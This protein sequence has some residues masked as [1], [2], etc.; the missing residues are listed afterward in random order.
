MSFYDPNQETVVA[1]DSSSYGLGGVLMQKFNGVLKPICYAS[2][3]LTATEQRYA[4]IEKEAL[5]LTWACEKFRTYLIGLSFHLQTDHKPL[6]ALF[7][8][9]NLD[10]LPPRIQRFRMRMMWFDYKVVY[11][12]GKLLSIADALS[13]SPICFVATAEDDLISEVEDHVNNVVTNFPAS[14]KMLQTI[15]DELLADPICSTVIKYCEGGWPSSRSVCH[16][17]QTFYQVRDD[18]AHQKGLLL[19]GDRIVIPLALQKEILNKLHQSH[20]GITKSRARARTVWWPGLSGDIKSFV[21]N[22][23]VCAQLRTNPTEPLI[24][25]ELPECSWQK[26]ACDL[27]N[28]NNAVYLL[29][30][31]YFSRWI[32]IALLDK[33]TTADYVISHLKS[34][35]AKFGIPNELRS[36]GGAQF[37]S[38]TFQKFANCY[39][40][41]HTFSSPRYPRSNG[42]AERAVQ[43]VK[44]LLKICN[45]PYLALLALRTSPLKTGYS[46]SELLMG[47]ELHTTVPAVPIVLEPK[48]SFLCDFKRK[49]KRVKINEKMNFDQRHQVRELPLLQD[50]SYVYVDDGYYDNKRDRIV[51]PADQPR[52][53]VVDISPNRVIRSRKYLKPCSDN[54]VKTET[55]MTG[56]PATAE[57][58]DDALCHENS[59]LRRSNYVTRS[60]RI[61]KPPQRLSYE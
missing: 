32:E 6:V 9:K 24:S 58:N 29:V 48:W 17:L 54:P 30:I 3:S 8:T 26:V 20:Q 2:R 37:L 61:S 34:T 43:T 35:F 1:A 52:S 50:D 38:F 25:S 44:N 33:G 16:V 41:V 31:D 5:A 49:E 36:D 45:D 15:R 57:L 23:S 53:Y 28:F 59:V 14:D 47:R 40:F 39:G 7:G 11:I 60:G 19:K 21:M 12:P 42:E 18:L 46:P 10:E 55:E 27:F 13:R 51:R 4:Q 22:C 56:T